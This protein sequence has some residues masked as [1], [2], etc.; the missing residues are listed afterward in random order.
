MLRGGESAGR[1]LPKRTGFFLG[2]SNF[3]PDEVK[4]RLVPGPVV[5]A[6][7]GSQALRK[8]RDLRRPLSNGL[9]RAAPSH[10]RGKMSLLNYSFSGALSVLAASHFTTLHT[11]SKCVCI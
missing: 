3:F 7:G 1:G 6:E 8:E 9:T 10:K 11:L 4:V 2:T 5:A